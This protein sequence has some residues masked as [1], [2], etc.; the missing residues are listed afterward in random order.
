[1]TTKSGSAATCCRYREKEKTWAAPSDYQTVACA[2]KRDA[3]IADG[4]ELRRIHAMNA[5]LLAHL[6]PISRYTLLS[7][8]I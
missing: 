4:K 3:E 8:Y 5:Q 2:Y 7:I 6:A 1:M